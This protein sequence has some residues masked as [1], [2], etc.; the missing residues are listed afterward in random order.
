MIGTVDFRPP[1]RADGGGR[2]NAVHSGHMHVHQDH[3]VIER[4]DLL[5]RLLAIAGEVDMVA[6]LGQESGRHQP[7]G[8]DVIDH[9]EA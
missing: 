5:H 2:S 4:L 7:V 8:G 3:I 9:Q 6:E 1:S